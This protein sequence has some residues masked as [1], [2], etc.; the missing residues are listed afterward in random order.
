MRN[1]AMSSAPSFL[2]ARKQGPSGYLQAQTNRMRIGL[3]AG[4]S[5]LERFSIDYFF[6]AS[7]SKLTLATAAKRRDTGLGLAPA[8]AT[9]FSRAFP[10]D[11]FSSFH[12]LSSLIDYIDSHPCDTAILH[13][14]EQY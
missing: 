4:E 5:W 3:V 14:Y 9:V 13:K 8:P 1:R 2:A 6:G 11:S 10:A 7:M 12:S